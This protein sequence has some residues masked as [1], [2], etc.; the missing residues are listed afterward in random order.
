[1]NRANDDETRARQAAEWL[2]RL[3]A[4]SVSRT[5]LDDFYIWRRDRENAAAYALA[6]RAWNDS[7][8]LGDDEDI[9]RAV[10]DALGRPRLSIIPFMTRRRV[11]AGGVALMALGSAGSWLALKT[12]ERYATRR[13]EQ[14]TVRL[15]DGSRMHL[16]TASRAEVRFQGHERLV[17]LEEGQAYFEVAHDPARPFKVR[18]GGLEVTAIGTRFDVRRLADSQVRVVLASGRI[19]V[20]AGRDWSQVLGNPGDALTGRPAAAP[21]L[22]HLDAQAATSWTNGRLVF[23]STPLGEALA[24]VNRY[25][26]KQVSL[27]G[28]GLAGLE[29]DGTFE[30]GDTDSFV[31]AVCALFSLRARS[32]DEHHVVLSRP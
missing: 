16:N 20:R 31:A 6:E 28:P 22:E 21:R 29:V 15:E 23:R 14:L 32:A 2:A 11:L 24:E 27:G 8:G 13:G 1:M 7:R 4:R 30:T 3:N 18:A 10:R 9:A 19:G 26:Q 17:Q 25:T 12:G 5:E